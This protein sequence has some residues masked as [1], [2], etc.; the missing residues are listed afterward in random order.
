MVGL[1]QGIPSTGVL[2]DNI[3]IAGPS[4]EEHFDNIEKVLR[5]LS[6]AGL[7]LKAVNCQFWSAWGTELIQSGF[8]LFKQK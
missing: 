1:P 6:E 2:L 4:T 3:L 8:I 5:R 7:R